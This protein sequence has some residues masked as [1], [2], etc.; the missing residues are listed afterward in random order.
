MSTA[1]HTL[2]KALD[3]YGLSAAYGDTARYGC[4]HINDTFRICTKQ[5]NYILQR[6]NTTVFPHPVELMENM[7]N[8]TNYLRR[9][10]LENGEDPDRGTLTLLPTVDG[11]QFYIDDENYVWRLTLLV[12]NSCCLQTVETPE[13]FEK[14]ARAF[15][16]FQKLLGSYPA[17]TLNETIARFHDTENRLENF[18]KALS[19]DKLGRAKDIQPEVQF[20]LDRADDCSVCMQALR[21]GILPL[22]VTHN[23]TKLNN[24]LFDENT[25]EDLCVLDLDTVMPGLS[26][27]DFGDSIRFGANHAAEDEPD[28]SKV[29]FDI[30]LY[31]IYVKGFLEE[32]ASVLTDAEIK[33]MPWG[34]KLMTLECGMRFLTDY[35]EG[36]VYFRISREH[37]NLD[38]CRTQLKLVADMEQHWQQMCDIVCAYIPKR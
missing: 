10:L 35:L 31:E 7:V 33:Y 29:N 34:A 6:I 21:D 32:A 26:I 13:Q 17:D 5:R 12:E 4:G 9:I 15:G 20:I 8:V 37:Q 24:V 1:E 38:R 16:R 28:L 11:K 23:D 25:G 19:E 22:R 3:A 27:N 36:D 30:A 2:A 14:S 18:R